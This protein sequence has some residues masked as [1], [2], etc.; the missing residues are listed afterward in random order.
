[1]KIKTTTNN[2]LENISYILFFGVVIIFIVY[3]YI[4]LKFGFWYMQPVFH[5]YDVAYM[6]KT[7]GIIND[8]LPEK[9]KYTEI[10]EQSNYKFSNAGE[11]QG[12]IELNNMYCIKN[13]C[14]HCKI[15]S[16]VMKMQ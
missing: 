7:P 3:I 9:N 13:K 16:S 11:T 1:M 14:I 8:Y 5:V 6:L 2:M 15:G 4:R 12:L 10:W